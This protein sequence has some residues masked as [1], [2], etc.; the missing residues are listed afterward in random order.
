[1]NGSYLFDILSSLEKRLLVLDVVRALPCLDLLAQPLQLLYLFLELSLVFLFLVEVS[2][3]LHL[4]ARQI[5]QLL[6]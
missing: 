4:Q 3:V 5:Q 2:R 1:M 6:S